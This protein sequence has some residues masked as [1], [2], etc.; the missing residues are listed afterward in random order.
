M[1]IP[2]APN[3]VTLNFSGKKRV[4]HVDNLLKHRDSVFYKSQFKEGCKYHPTDITIDACMSE[5]LTDQIV[6]YLQF[7]IAPVASNAYDLAV[8]KCV[9]DIFKLPKNVEFSVN[10]KK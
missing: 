10:I 6:A 5:D 9:W 7:D 4:I 3:F 8:L 1:S 2:Q